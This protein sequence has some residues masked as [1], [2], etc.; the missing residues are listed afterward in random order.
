MNLIKK[1]RDYFG[2]KKEEHPTQ[3][4][5]QYNPTIVPGLQKRH[6]DYLRDLY[7]LN[8]KRQGVIESKN[9]Q[10]VGQASIIISIFALFI[11]LLIGKLINLNIIVLFVLILVFILILFHYIL[12]IYHSTK[13]LEINRYK[14]SN[15]SIVTVTD[16][17]RATT[18]NDFINEEIEDLIKG[19]ENNTAQTNRKGENLIFATRSFRF[20]SIVFAIFTLLVIGASFFITS[21]PQEMKVNGINKSII[22]TLDSKAIKYLDEYNLKSET[23]N[24]LLELQKMN[25]ILDSLNGKIL[26]PTKNIVHLADSAKNK[27]DSNK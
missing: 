1:Y 3:R 11:P 19:I 27:D 21:E 26:C 7:N 17:N 23:K 10:L 5:F 25:I 12:T 6:L 16:A 2:I 15:P 18:E 24:I 20:A 9:S 8:K 14:Y 13:T 22:D 4:A